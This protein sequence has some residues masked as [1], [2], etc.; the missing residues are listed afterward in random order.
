MDSKWEDL[1]F[2]G[3]KRATRTIFEGDLPGIKSRG[4]IELK[5]F[6]FYDFTG[7]VIESFSMVQITKSG[8]SVGEKRFINP[9]P[10]SDRVLES[11]NYITEP[12]DRFDKASNFSRLLVKTKNL[13]VLYQ[14]LLLSSSVAVFY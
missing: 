9:F 11:A 7:K 10:C 6:P 14:F 12:E 13:T 1:I 3:G 8:S 4:E 2:K 5:Q